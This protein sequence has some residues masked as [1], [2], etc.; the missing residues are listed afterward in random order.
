M[1]AATSGLVS[2][3]TFSEGFEDPLELSDDEI[4]RFVEELEGEDEQARA[5]LRDA[6]P[7]AS[8]SSRTGP[9][10]HLLL[11]SRSRICKLHLT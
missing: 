9:A 5:V 6:L 4:D 3:T 10:G 2:A 1:A 8:L 7:P 11:L